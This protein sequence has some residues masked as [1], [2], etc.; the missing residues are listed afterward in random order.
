[1]RGGGRGEEGQ[2]RPRSQLTWLILCVLVVAGCG[3]K[4]VRAG[5]DFR[6]VVAQGAI[7]ARGS[8]ASCLGP[9]AAHLR[10]AIAALASLALGTSA[11]QA[12]ALPVPA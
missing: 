7:A 6:A 9:A 10:A 2:A 1:M 12:L 5:Q 4:P 3:L 8:L 11:C